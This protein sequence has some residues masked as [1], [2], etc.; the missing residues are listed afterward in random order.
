VREGR[1]WLTAYVRVQVHRGRRQRVMPQVVADGGRFSTARK[2]WV[3]W[4]C[5]VQ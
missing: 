4:V 3:A 1:R 5:L 2:A